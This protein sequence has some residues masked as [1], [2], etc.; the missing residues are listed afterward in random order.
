[1][2]IRVTKTGVEVISTISPSQQV[3]LS[4][5][6]I[7]ALVS[8]QSLTLPGVRLSTINAEVLVS[9]QTPV[10]KPGVR[11]S[12]INAE[13][14]VSIDESRRFLG[15]TEFTSGL[16]YSTLNA[17]VIATGFNT[18]SGATVELWFKY[19]ST[20]SI[21]QNYIFAISGGDITN[22][23]LFNWSNDPVTAGLYSGSSNYTITNNAAVNPINGATTAFRYTCTSS[24]ASFIG[25]QMNG[26]G[27]AGIPMTTWIWIKGEGS[28]IGKVIDMEHNNN[29]VSAGSTTFT[30]T[31]SW[32]KVSFSFTPGASGNQI[33]YISAHDTPG[34]NLTN[35]DTFLL[36]NWQLQTTANSSSTLEILNQATLTS[37]R[38]AFAARIDDTTKHLLVQYRP[39]TLTV[40][41]LAEIDTGQVL[42][43]DTWYHLAMSANYAGK[44]YNTYL[45]GTSINSYTYGGTT[46]AFTQGSNTIVDYLGNHNQS[47]LRLDP[48][49]HLRILDFRTYN[50]AKSNVSIGSDFSSYKYALIGDT[51]LKKSYRLPNPA[52]GTII[53][54]KGK[55]VDGSYG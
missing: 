35:G 32:Q 10:N 30:L 46:V 11:L 45:N 51:T 50:F 42:T 41:D 20:S 6:N 39:S 21:G 28:S 48:T 1:M 7:E 25:R 54:A 44:S 27:I 29:G 43:V 15:S 37:P 40:D 4:T 13:V 47:V 16:G 18:L 14:L 38:H 49:A 33:I 23:N 9:P 3:R 52:I 36:Y 2:A 12:T 31:S 22:K 53:D 19:L 17:G 24:S 8:P 34:G 55:T 26:L 5:V